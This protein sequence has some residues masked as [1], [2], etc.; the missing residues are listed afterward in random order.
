MIGA[1]TERSTIFIRFET[2]KSIPSFCRGL[3]AGFVSNIRVTG[4]H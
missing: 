3:E 2:C 4:T 1:H